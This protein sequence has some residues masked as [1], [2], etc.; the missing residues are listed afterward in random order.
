MTMVLML[1]PRFLTRNDQAFNI[2]CN[3][4]EISQKFTNRIEV[5]ALPS[6]DV[7]NSNSNEA[8]SI[9]AE[10]KLPKCKYEV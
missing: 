5:S 10:A 4:V 3:Y 1:H 2:K 9:E 6:T 8:L 7:P